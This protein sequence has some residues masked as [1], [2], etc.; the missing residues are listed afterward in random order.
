M[1]VE[2]T[3]LLHREVA[4]LELVECRLRSLELLEAAGQERFV[5]SALAD[6]EDAA[7]HL[8]ALEL[9]RAIAVVGAGLPADATA[10][11]LLELIDGAAEGAA[12]SAAVD[13]LRTAADRV[14]VA[15]ERA[16]S[17]VGAGAEHTAGRLALAAQA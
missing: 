6:L 4:A 12:L 7:E 2:L 17:V 8:G 16:G 14:A 3:E 10:T 1:I 13:R 9:G 5:A 11:D 15:R